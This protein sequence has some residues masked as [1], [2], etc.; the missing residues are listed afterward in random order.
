MYIISLVSPA[1]LTRQL[2]RIIPIVQR[3]KL[4]PWKAKCLPEARQLVR[5]Q[6]EIQILA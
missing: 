2:I 6:M 5:S 1:Y 3:R 4:R